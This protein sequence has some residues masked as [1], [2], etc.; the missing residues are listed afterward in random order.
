MVILVAV[1]VA[2]VLAVANGIWIAPRLIRW[3]DRW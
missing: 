3:R 1:V 2:N